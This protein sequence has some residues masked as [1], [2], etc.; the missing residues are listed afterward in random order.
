[1]VIVFRTIDGIPIASYLLARLSNFVENDYVLVFLSAPVDFRPGWMWMLK[2]YRALDRKYKKNL[3]AL[4][5]VHLTRVYRIVFDL[6]NKITSPKFARKLHYLPTLDHLNLVIPVAQL[7]PPQPVLDYDFRLPPIPIPESL[8]TKLNGDLS[9]TG[10][11]TFGRSIVELMRDEDER[12]QKDGVPWVVRTLVE[13][14]RLYGLDKEGLFRKSPSSEQLRLVKDAFNRG[15]AIDLTHHDVH[16]PAVLVK[17]F[18]RE[19][20]ESLLPLEVVAGVGEFDKLPA[21]E[22]AAHIRHTLVTLSPTP[23]H[24]PLMRYLFSFLHLVAAHSSENLMTPHNI[25]VVFTPNLVHAE[26]PQVV[27]YPRSQARIT[28]QASITPGGGTGLTNIGQAQHQ[29]ENMA[30]AAKYLSQMGRGMDLVA[31]LVEEWLEVFG[32]GEGEGMTDG[33]ADAEVLRAD[34]VRI[35]KVEA[36]WKVENSDLTRVPFIVK[37]SKMELLMLQQSAVQTFDELTDGVEGIRIGGEVEE[38]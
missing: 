25:A 4:Y 12:G 27:Q 16:I 18:F 3:K 23:Y 33:E 30:S 26:V 29:D 19:L 6:A 34:S 22:R 11:R 9:Q 13:H 35:S 28:A 17:V 8:L 15:R 38:I 7:H 31:Y 14:L 10:H 5:V 21:D 2:A 24:I 1:M 36:A 37:D 32:T 20:P